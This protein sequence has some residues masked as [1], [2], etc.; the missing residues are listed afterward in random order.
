MIQALCHRNQKKEPVAI[1]LLSCS[2]L[3][4]ILETHVAPCSTKK[5]T[6]APNF[7]LFA[8]RMA[9]RPHLTS[10]STKCSIM[11]NPGGV[12][13]LYS[14]SSVTPYTQ[15]ARASM[16][17]RELARVTTPPMA[18]KAS[19]SSLRWRR[20]IHC[21]KELQFFLR[22]KTAK[23]SQE[24]LLLWGKSAKLLSTTQIL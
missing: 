20:L 23:V 1:Y 7:T 22:T 12:A 16:S 17:S 15:H 5:T 4:A 11:W 13:N 9:S 18:T 10:N 2:R 21:C 6:T 19:L 3:P 14:T 8:W 24:L